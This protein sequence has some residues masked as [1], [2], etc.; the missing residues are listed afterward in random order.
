MHSRITF[1]VYAK[2]GQVNG[3]AP[4]ESATD[5]TVPQ[6]FEGRSFTVQ[7]QFQREFK[8]NGTEDYKYKNIKII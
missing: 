6:H 2:I 1:Y 4:P 5:H 8:T 7:L 3:G